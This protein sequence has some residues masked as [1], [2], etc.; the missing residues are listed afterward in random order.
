MP[1]NVET[2]N[3]WSST[4]HLYVSPEVIMSV[5][6]TYS[7]ARAKLA[8]YLDAAVDDR[9]TVIISRRGR[10]DVALIAA[11]ELASLI[12]TSHLLKSPKNAERLREA[13]GSA[14]AGEG[15]PMTV[16]ELRRDVGLDVQR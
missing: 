11:D 10:P 13:L 12:E 16:D 5:R 3:P 2:D 8:S 6:T 15:T 9:E 7:E 14:L 4:M 1:P